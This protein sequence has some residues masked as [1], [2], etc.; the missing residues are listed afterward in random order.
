[1]F[2]R[3]LSFLFAWEVLLSFGFVVGFALREVTSVN[4]PMEG[5]RE[6]NGAGVR[7]D[8]RV[9]TLRHPASETGNETL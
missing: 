4:D 6:A 3:D 5:D 1:M 7:W 9:R 8:S 2:A